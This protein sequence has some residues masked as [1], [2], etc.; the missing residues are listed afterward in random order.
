M[1]CRVCGGKTYTQERNP[2][3]GKH[4]PICDACSDALDKAR[5]EEK[6][7]SCTEAHH[8]ESWSHRDL[9]ELFWIHLGKY[10]KSPNR[11]SLNYLYM[12]WLWAC[13]EDHGLTS[14]FSNALD[15]CKIDLYAERKRT[16]LPEE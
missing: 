10:V 16:D 15:W 3:T 14:N 9:S 11:K 2:E 8:F 6:A 7:K 13:H 4:E 12:A 1:Q 5:I